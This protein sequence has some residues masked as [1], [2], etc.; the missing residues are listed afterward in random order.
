MLLADVNIF[1]HAHREDSPHHALC[2][3]WLR[4]HLGGGEPLGLSELVLSSFVRIV[5]NHRIFVNAT[6]TETALDFCAAMLAAPASAVVRPGP[7]H[8]AIF[9]A[10]CRRVHAR[11]NVVPDAY[12]AA[13]A[14]EQGA[15]LVTL[16]A[17]FHRFPGLRIELP[18]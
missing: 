5:T 14:L 8:W 4:S 3:R 1:I 11:A 6:P 7:R 10:L 12:L 17:G 9:D 2:D 13:Q 16:D 18:G 15:R